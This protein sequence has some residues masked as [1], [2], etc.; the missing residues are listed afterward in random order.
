MAPGGRLLGLFVILA[1]G[2]WALPPVLAEVTQAEVTGALGGLPRGFVANRGQWDSRAAWSAP[3][4]YGSTW[5]TR[6]G[7]LRHVLVA[8]GDCRE[9]ETK[10][11]ALVRGREKPCPGRSWVV[12]E[13]FVGGKVTVMEGQDPLPTQ[14]SYF[15]GNDPAK[16]RSGLATYGRLSL[17]EVWPGVRVELVATQK[18]VEK[19]L[20]VGPGVDPSVIRVAVGGA[21]AVNINAKGELVV[22][23]GYGDAVLSKPVAWQEA[24]GVKKPVEV[25]YRLDVQRKSYTFALGP[26]DRTRPVTIDPILQSTY[27][28]GSSSDQAYALALASS[29]DVYVAGETFSTNFPGTAGGAQASFAGG[30]DAFVARLNGTLTSLTQATYLGGSSGDFASALAL[31]GAGDV[32]VAGFTLS[33]NFPGTA[34]GAQASKGGGSDA[35]VARLNGTLT[36]LTQATY[37]GGSFDESAYALA[38]GSSGDVYVAGYTDSWN[39]P[40]T[41]GGA[42]ASFGGGLRDAFVARLDSTLAS[43]MQSTYL[44]GS[45]AESAYALALGSS[46]D[47]YVAGETR[48]TNFPGTAGG[49]QASNGGSWDAFVARLNGTL[50]S[51]TQATY[52]GGSGGEF[53][54]ALALSSSGDVYVA[55]D[56]DSTNFP[57][58]SGGAQASFAGGY[59]AF[60]ARLNGALTSLTQATYLGGSGAESG[61]ALALSSSGDV[62]VAGQTLSLNFPGTAGGAQTTNAGFS[63]AF[64]AR[65]T[66]TLTSLTQAT[67]L[68]GSDVDGASALALSSAGDVYVAGRT[69]STNFPGTSGGAQAS[70]GGQSDAFVARLT[71][72]L[73]AAAQ[74]ADMRANTPSVPPSLGPGGSYPLFFSCTNN[75]PDAATN[76]T[77]GISPSVG[78]VSGVSCSPSVPVA[79]LASGNTISCTCIFTAPGAQGGGNTPETGVTFTVTASASTTDPNT[80][81][82]TATSGATPIPI[83][84][85][86]NDAGSFPANT[87][88]AT[89][90][91]GS[92]DQYGAG[93]LPSSPAPTFSLLG[94]TT[95]GG[96]SI[97]SAGVATFNVPASGTCTVEYRVCVLSGCDTATLSVTAQQV[98]AIPTLQEWGMLVL[99]LLVAST[100]VRVLRRR[101]LAS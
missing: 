96:A 27:L 101:V 63:D 35:F 31:S 13:R 58:T 9:E 36:S 68:G 64:V 46:G 67:Y 51:L 99:T 76:A 94:G 29:G 37:L 91:V 32:Y 25:S 79:S 18:T 19:V 14:V 56:T 7:E 88:G 22:T 85:A 100:A 98:E 49:A 12:S 5:V 17:G 34:G 89:F 75:G 48:S 59:D 15:L 6:D 16:H 28:G 87:V 53:E 24:G 21:Q 38:L 20:V 97:N 65:L 82:N 57:G 70:N 72:D 43:L 77:C 93:S 42:Q 81:N 78:T 33:T 80:T 90:N 55:G 95:C 41:A 2:F 10:G 30:Y 92:N 71:A 11:E 40:G 84:D 66:G 4:F 62:Y 44:G 47:V 61:P 69:Y 50:T 26:Y 83:V 54:P 8:R 74:S 45:L 52:L 73:A 86:V 23:T 1:V 3:G 60:V 39:F